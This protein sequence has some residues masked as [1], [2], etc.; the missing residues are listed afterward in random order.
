MRRLID[1]RGRASS[2]EFVI[3]FVFSLVAAWG[4]ALL[5]PPQPHPLVTIGLSMVLVVPVVGVIT[6]RYHDFGS[7]G[8]LVAI[9]FGLNLVM[10][11]AANTVRDDVLR[12]LAQTI[13]VLLLALQGLDLMKVLNR[14]PDPE[15]NAFGDVPPD[16]ASHLL[17]PEPDPAS[18]DDEGWDDDG[19]EDD[20]ALGDAPGPPR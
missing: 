9:L 10:L 12:G 13:P 19:W 16:T 18:W 14:R 11:S 4:S 6:R 2:R 8:L 17:A 5:F 20:V 7:R 3:T 15:A 1:W